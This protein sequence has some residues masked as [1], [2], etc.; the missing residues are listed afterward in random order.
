MAAHKRDV[1]GSG[2]TVKEK[3]D[4]IKVLILNLFV[5][6]LIIVSLNPNLKC[7]KIKLPITHMR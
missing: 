3:R 4:L 5:V 6:R 1:C 7:H 2:S